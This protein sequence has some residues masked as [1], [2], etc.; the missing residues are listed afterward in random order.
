[1]RDQLMARLLDDGFD[2]RPTPAVLVAQAAGVRESVASK[3]LAALSP[4]ATAQA[5]TLPATRAPLRRSRHPLKK[6]APAV[7]ALRTRS[8]P[9]RGSRAGVCP[10]KTASRATKLASRTP[11]KKQRKGKAAGVTKA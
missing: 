8:C 3:V 2:N 9:R 11:A 4:I 7:L 1:M 10:H 5:D 6:A